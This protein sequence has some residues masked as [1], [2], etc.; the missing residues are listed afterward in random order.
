V[1]PKLKVGDTLIA[2]RPKG[3]WQ[4]EEVREVKVTGVGRLYFTLDWQVKSKFRVQDWRQADYNESVNNPVNLYV[5][6]DEMNAVM[7]RQKQVTDLS[8]LL[9]YQSD[10]R[11]LTSE[12]IS[13]IHKIVFP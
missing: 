5:S 1:K 9:H 6:H 7:I 4:N 12:Q 10:W 11:S 13:A 8:N 3:R 2:H